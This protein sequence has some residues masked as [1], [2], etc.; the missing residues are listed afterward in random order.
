MG[1]VDD[2]VGGMGSEGVSGGDLIGWGQC[3][4]K[5]ECSHHLGILS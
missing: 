1:G 4:T 5:R 3:D 2:G